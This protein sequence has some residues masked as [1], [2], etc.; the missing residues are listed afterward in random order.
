MASRPALDEEVEVRASTDPPRPRRADPE[1][2][3][4]RAVLGMLRLAPHLDEGAEPERLGV[5]LDDHGDGLEWHLAM[6]DHI[7]QKI[8]VG[9]HSCHSWQDHSGSMITAM[10][11]IALIIALTAVVVGFAGLVS[12]ARRDHFAGGHNRAVRR[13]DLGH[14][15]AAR[16][17]F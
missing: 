2:E 14:T 16:L 1:V 10:T 5:V 3:D 7:W 17:A 15:D 12:Y 4:G 13:D 9:C 6:V 8:N 11:T